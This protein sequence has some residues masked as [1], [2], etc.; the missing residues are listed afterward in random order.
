METLCRLHAAIIA[1]NGWRKCNRSSF[2]MVALIRSAFTVRRRLIR[3]KCSHIPEEWAIEQMNRIEY[4]M[5]TGN[6]LN[7]ARKNQ[8]VLRVLLTQN[9]LKKFNTMIDGN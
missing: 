1:A 4:F 3:Q 7:I 9:F 6:A 8:D 2:K 5:A